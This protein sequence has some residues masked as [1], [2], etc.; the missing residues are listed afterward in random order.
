MT[1]PLRKDAG[2]SIGRVSDVVVREISLAE[3]RPLRHAVLRPHETVAS[4]TAHEPSDAFAVGVFDGGALVA[5]GFIGADGE[6][7]A[8]RVRG[9][10]TAPAARGKGAGSAVLDGLLGHAV[11]FGASRVWCNVRT[12]A[13]SLYERAGFRA[14]SE[15][16]ELP[17]IGPHFVMELKTASATTTVGTT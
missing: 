14:V 11:A 9:M 15:E 2:P 17:G 3:T 12:P 1:R 4:L 16:F 13:R 6:P 5:V 10:A 7:G 8:W